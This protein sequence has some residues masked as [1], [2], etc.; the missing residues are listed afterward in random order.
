MAVASQAVAQGRT[1]VNVGSITS[2]QTCVYFRTYEGESLR[3]SEAEY[4]R[5]WGA[6]AARRFYLSHTTWRSSVEEDCR[7]NFINLRKT[8]EA[9]LAST[10]KLTS[11]RGGYTIDLVISDIGQTPPAQSRPVQGGLDYSLSWGKAKVTLSYTL[12]D[13][14]GAAVDGGVMTKEITMSQ[15]INTAGFTSTTVEPGDLV[16]DLVQNEVAMTLARKVAFEIEPLRVIA[17]EN[18]LIEVNYGDPLLSLGDQID[19]RKTRGIGVIRYRVTQALSDSSIA[20]AQGNMSY[21]DID[22]GN[23]V[24]FIEK[25]SDAANA[26]VMKG[27]KLP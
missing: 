11:G 1:P 9:A 14:S 8:L 24:T 2:T 10:G 27:K 6:A 12:K 26:P 13:R 5:V 19:V 15:A 4:A 22:A 17:V 20:E 18:D 23:L 7:E 25:D 21:E 3:Y 16:Y